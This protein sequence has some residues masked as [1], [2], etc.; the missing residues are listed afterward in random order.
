MMC[1]GLSLGSALAD[2]LP[3]RLGAMGDSLSDEYFEESY[4]YAKNWSILLVERRS[5]SITM[6]P[7]AAQGGAG[8]TW[9]EPR[10]TGY[11]FNWARYDADSSTA[12]T[13]GQHTSLAAQVASSGV[14]HAVVAIG[15]NDFAPTS[16][17][18]FNI[19]WGFWSST[20]IDNYVNARIANI[21]AAVATLS[22]AQGPQG[23][24]GIVLGNCVDFGGTP[25]VRQ[26]YANAT[27]R[28]RVT[29]VIARV[30][31]G[32]AG[33]AQNRRAV[34][35]DLN[36]MA[37]TILGTNAS[38]RS[39]LPIGGVNIQLLNR[40]TASHTNPLAGFVDDGGHPHTTLQGAF[41]NAIM[42]AVNI[43]WPGAGGIATNTTRG[44][45]TGLALFTDQ[46]ILQAAGIVPP[47]GE[48]QT[49]D[50]IIGGGGY[51]AYITNHRCAADLGIQG[52]I[53]GAGTGDGVLDNNDFIA[54]I[55]LFFTQHPA[56][57][58][59][60]QGG[61]P[62]A[63]GQHDNNDFVVFIDRFFAGC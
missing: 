22:Q 21:D 51:A 6:G 43:G 24:M 11:A 31:V 41:A 9:G 38:P 33:I 17:A 46:E 2:P 8:A 16:S 58:M 42:S 13:Q 50:T 30:N 12:L 7:T 37:R 35:L 3:I 26:L 36:A 18:Y 28:D 40:D 34:L 59:G 55:D 14:S 1:A 54:F 19:Y 32:V 45:G 15:A 27:R 25:I 23:K 61:I 57:D 56:A 60:I 63:D 52:G 49:L 5:T 20:Q 29:N 4:D 48:P 44:G 47:S 10:R 39:F 62:G 53:T